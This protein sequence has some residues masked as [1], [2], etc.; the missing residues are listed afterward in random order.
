MLQE[1]RNE[2]VNLL[3]YAP[4]AS[5][6]LAK[7]I[8]GHR[9]VQERMVRENLWG[10]GLFA[11]TLLH[12]DQAEAWEKL[13]QIDQLYAE[14][15]RLILENSADQLAFTELSRQMH[16]SLPVVFIRDIET[17][18][19]ILGQVASDPELEEIFAKARK[20]IL[21]LD[22][23]NACL[24][25][26]WVAGTGEQWKSATSGMNFRNG[27]FMLSVNLAK[28]AQ[29]IVDFG[30]KAGVEISLEEA[31]KYLNILTGLHEICHDLN[32]EDSILIELEADMPA[33]IYILNQI[34]SLDKTKMLLVMWTEYICNLGGGDGD[35]YH[36][37]S[38][39][40]LSMM[41]A[42]GAVQE[43]GGIPVVDGSKTGNFINKLKEV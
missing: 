37:S 20:D 4:T 1:Y 31:G 11:Q 27:V 18:D 35:P 3:S 32:G 12:I 39:M 40:I 33:C 19:V 41:E 10:L 38:R 26:N 7:Q 16:K 29:K 42:S 25:I 34:A 43:I 2:G 14:F 28:N 8:A 30:Q 24:L 22:D 9:R 5:D 15:G 6:L 13:G 17:G 21:G 36:Y 23:G